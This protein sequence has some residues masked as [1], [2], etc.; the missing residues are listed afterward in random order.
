MP[1]KYQ[2]NVLFKPLMEMSGRIKQASRAVKA[3]KKNFPTQNYSGLVG[4]VKNSLP[5]LSGPVTTPYGGSTKFEKF[6]PGIDIAEPIGT[7]VGAMAPGVV[8]SVS[9]GKK[10][11]DPGYGNYVVVTDQYGGQHRYSHLAKA[12]VPVGT[13]VTKGMVIGA[14]GNTGSTYS[15]SG[16]G[17]G[18][19]LDYRIM[20]AFRKYVN[21]STYLSNYNF[22]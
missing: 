11:G 14:I 5:F 12:Y 16:K 9:T 3:S 10:Q 7:P 21:P 8:T 2:E 18:A 13:P 22:S 17:N 4:A 6:H 1:E 15:P 20:D 19:H